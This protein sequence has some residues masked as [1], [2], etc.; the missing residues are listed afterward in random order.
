MDP[1]SVCAQSE[2]AAHMQLTIDLE[3]VISRHFIETYYGYLLLPNCHPAFHDGWIRDIQELMVDDKGLRYAVL[4]NAASH[5]HNMD[6][7]SGMQSLALKYY[8]KSIQGLSHVLIQA[9]NP[10]LTSCNGLLMSIMLLY[11]HGV[12]WISTV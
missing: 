7:N 6:T 11:L 4:A 12:S 9:N 10:Y 1:P 2:Q 8:S 3:V 5:I